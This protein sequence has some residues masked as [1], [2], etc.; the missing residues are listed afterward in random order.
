MLYPYLIGLI[1]DTQ[2]NLNNS[3]PNYLNIWFAL[4]KVK[5]KMVSAPRLFNSIANFLIN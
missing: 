4:F 2:F 1:P 3:D 5:L